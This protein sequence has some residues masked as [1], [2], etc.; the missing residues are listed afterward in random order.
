MKVC[1]LIENLSKLDPQSELVMQNDAEGNGY[2]PLAGID[3]NAWYV[4]ENDYSGQVYSERWSA[5]D[6]D[7][8]EDEWKEMRQQRKCV[9]L[10]P[11][12]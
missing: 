11:V 5:E 3:S 4:A 1:E 12:N 7:L 8:E 9:V 10:F 6:C 2:S